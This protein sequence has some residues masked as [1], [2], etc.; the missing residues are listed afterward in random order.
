MFKFN[1]KYSNNVLRFNEFSEDFKQKSIYIL[2]PKTDQG[3][4]VI[5]QIKA[6]T[7]AV[8]VEWSHII[9]NK[10][11][12]IKKHLHQMSTFILNSPVFPIYYYGLILIL[13]ID[14]FNAALQGRQA[15]QSTC[16]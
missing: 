5:W 14:K 11:N 6:Y 2:Q 15:F 16:K 3:L 9:Y 8:M 12:C 7:A 4:G 10:S 13:Y 1:T